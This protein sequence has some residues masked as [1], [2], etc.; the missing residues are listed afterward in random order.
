MMLSSTCGASTH[1]TLLRGQPW[2]T[3]HEASCSVKP[4]YCVA[5]IECQPAYSA[6]VFLSRS[7]P[8]YHRWKLSGYSITSYSVR[9]VTVPPQ[10]PGI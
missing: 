8:S 7:L 2:N 4:A 6:N 10:N 1:T 5:L 9:S 3:E